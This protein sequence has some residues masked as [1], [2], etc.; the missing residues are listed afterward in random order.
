MS[1]R[2][3]RSIS[4]QAARN[5][6]ANTRPAYK[7]DVAKEL[8]KIRR[9]NK[10]LKKFPK[11]LQVLGKAGNVMHALQ[12]FGLGAGEGVTRLRYNKAKRKIRKKR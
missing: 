3:K 11:P 8:K 10:N 7:K 12:G 2:K 1:R 6:L 5:V 4:R 9:L